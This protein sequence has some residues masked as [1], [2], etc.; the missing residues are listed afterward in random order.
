VKGTTLFTGAKVNVKGGRLFKVQWRMAIMNTT[1][2]G[3]QRKEKCRDTEN[4][5]EKRSNVKIK[6][7]AVLR[8]L[9]CY[10]FA[11]FGLL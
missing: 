5:K 10:L 7:E 1:Q 11:V 8:V 4:R 3:T 6:D 9:A 2:E